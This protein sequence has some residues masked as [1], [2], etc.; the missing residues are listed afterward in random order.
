MAKSKPKKNKQVDN[1]IKFLFGVF[2]AI[3]LFSGTVSTNQAMTIAENQVNSIVSSQGLTATVTSYVL[4][5]GLYTVFVDVGQGDLVQE[6]EVYLT[7]DGDILIVGNA[8]ETSG[9]EDGPDRAEFE[10]DGSELSLGD[11]NAPVTVIEFSDFQCPFCTRF[12]EGTIKELKVNYVDTGKVYYVYKH[13]PLSFHAS[14][15]I[16]GEAVECAN[17]QEAWYEY[18]AKIFDA[19]DGDFT[20]SDLKS[21]AV[22]IV[23]DTEAFGTCLDSGKYESKIKADMVEGQEAGVSGTPATFVNGIMVSGAQPYSAFSELVDSE[24]GE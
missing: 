4:E 24:L 6:A 11:P 18:H 15:Q 2:A 21:W 13:F 17:E 1:G 16:A 3:M 19:Q 7:R 9:S 20:K 8:Y 10:L 14:A 5:N 12:Y 23:P 22:G